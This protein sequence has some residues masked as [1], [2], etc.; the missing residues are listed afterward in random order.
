M[1]YPINEEAKYSTRITHQC[2]ANYMRCK[3]HRKK[4]KKDKGTHGSFSPV[5][6]QLF[7]KM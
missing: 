1:K 3:C 7:N 5:I 2:N 6:I 4:G